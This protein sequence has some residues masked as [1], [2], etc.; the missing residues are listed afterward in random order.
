[1]RNLRLLWLI[2]IALLLAAGARSETLLTDEERAKTADSFVMDAG[3][4]IANKGRHVKDPDT[5]SGWAV[6]ADPKEQPGQG[7]LWYGYTYRQVP[8]RVRVVYRLK[9][10]DNTIAEPVAT[11][12][13]CFWNND[14]KKNPNRGAVPIK[15]TDFTAPNVYQEFSFEIPKGE[16][17]FGGWGVSTTGKTTLTFD[18][19]RVEQISR[20]TAQDLLPLLNLPEKPANLALAADKFIVHEAV[21]LFTEHWGVTPAVGL[22]LASR[23]PGAARTASY[24]ESMHGQRIKLHGYPMKWEE[25]YANR[26]IVLNNVS[27][28]VVSLVGTVMLKSFM[29]DGGTVIFLGDSHG[30]IGGKWHE[31]LLEPVFPIDLAQTSPAVYS[32]KPLYLQPRAASLKGADWT[33]KPYTVYSHKTAL[34]PGTTV[35]LA[36]GDVPLAV[37]R[38]VGKGR[39]VVLLLSVYGE[40]N[41]KAPGVP[42]WEWNHWPVVM[43][44]LLAP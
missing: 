27:A 20:F 43:G 25:L 23:F 14:L 4:H 19:V 35:L 40:K 44:G 30:L 9:V 33:K 39:L 29:E 18:T 21:G 26:V 34:R 36:A 13:V 37:E 42:F 31:S 11:V 15:G 41:P 24:F 3:S 16:V 28:Q 12:Q 32:T 2:C 5:R 1:M 6:A 17:G 10:A 38:K 7:Y 8:G 22:V